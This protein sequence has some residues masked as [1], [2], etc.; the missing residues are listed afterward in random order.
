M[1]RICTLTGDPT[2]FDV[3]KAEKAGGRVDGRQ[4]PS[5]AIIMLLRDFPDQNAAIVAKNKLIALGFPDAF[6]VKEINNDGVLKRMG[7]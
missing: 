7:L 6:V 3:K 2:K 1:V 4:E 5:G